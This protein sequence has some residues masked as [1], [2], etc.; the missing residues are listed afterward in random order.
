MVKGDSGTGDLLLMI[1]EK[2]RSRREGLEE[3]RGRPRLNPLALAPKENG[4]RTV[5]CVIGLPDVSR[6]RLEAVDFFPGNLGV[7][8]E[9][10]QCALPGESCWEIVDAGAEV[11][12]Q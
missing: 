10:K 4:C 2:K 3:G 5:S 12:D 6:R 1:L 11:S 8:F 9:Q 7:D